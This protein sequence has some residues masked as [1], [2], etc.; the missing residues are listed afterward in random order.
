VVLVHEHAVHVGE[1]A[2][3]LF[4]SSHA[5]KPRARTSQADEQ[6]MPEPH[7]RAA[8]VVQAQSVQVR[9]PIGGHAPFGPWGGLLVGTRLRRGERHRPCSGA[10]EVIPEPSLAGFER[11]G[12]GVSGLMGVR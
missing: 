7:A 5:V 2:L 4:T 10:R 12:D 11:G 9:A 1:P 3:D 8:A 6:R